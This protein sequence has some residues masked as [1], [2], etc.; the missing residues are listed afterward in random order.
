MAFTIQYTGS[1]DNKYCKI[2][3]DHF[4]QIKKT[5]KT[6]TFGQMRCDIYV[7][8]LID[9]IP[10]MNY[11]DKC[12]MY[13]KSRE[14]VKDRN[15]QLHL[16]FY[17]IKK[18]SLTKLLYQLSAKFTSF[19]NKLKVNVSNARWLYFDGNTQW[20]LAEDNDYFYE[21]QWQGS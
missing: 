16:D 5:K 13:K 20:F 11:S 3:Y 4:L 19:P 8:S 21:V 17:V 15:K 14:Y 2:G 10:N 1:N 18:I 9:D 12:R 6:K 7:D